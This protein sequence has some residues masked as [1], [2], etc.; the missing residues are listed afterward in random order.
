M[1]LRGPEATRVGKE[2]ADAPSSLW[3]NSK[4]AASS[5]S[6]RPGLISGNK[7]SQARSVMAVALAISSISAGDFTIRRRPGSPSL[8]TSR[9]A[10]TCP[11]RN[12]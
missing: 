12:R 4:R 3:K 5:S 1:A 7:R 9:S 2:A 6:R 11:A 8:G 10:P